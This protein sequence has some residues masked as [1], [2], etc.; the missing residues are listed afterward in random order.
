MKNQ[1]LLKVV[2]ILTVFFSLNFAF[3]QN[4]KLW[5]RFDNPSFLPT[6]DADGSLISSNEALTTLIGQNNMSGFEQ[7][8]PNSKNV[9]L[10]KVYEIACT[11]SAH[12]ITNELYKLPF[13]GLVEEAPNYQVLY[14]PDDYNVTL[15]ADYA[16]N[17]INAQGAWDISQGSD[18]VVIAIS[19]QNYYQHHEELQ[20]KIVYYD[21]TNLTT[22]THG[23]AIA[24]LAAGNTNNGIGFSS[25]GFKCKLALYK[26]SFNEILVAS[27][28]GVD[29]IN[30]SW[31]SGCFY[32][33][34][35]QDVINE[36]YNNG[37]F[38][39]A[40]AGNGTTC[41]GADNIVFP[42]S[43]ANVFAV[44]SVGPTDNHESIIGDPLSTHQHN[45]SV[46]ISAPGYGV[47]ISAA[48]SWYFN[49]SGTSYAAAYVSGTVGLMLAVNKCITNTDI[50]LILKSSSEN[51]DSLNPLYAGKIGSGRLD[52]QQALVLTTAHIGNLSLSTTLVDGCTSNDVAITASFIG[53]QAPHTVAWSNGA[54]SLDI[55]SLGAGANQITITDAHGCFVNQVVNVVD[56]QEPILSTQVTDVYCFGDNNGAV[57]LVFANPVE[58]TSVLWNN[59]NT[60]NALYNVSEGVYSANITYNG[61]LCSFTQTAIVQQPSVLSI[62]A[63]ITNIDSLNNTG[64]IDVSV[65]GGTAP[66]QFTWNNNE[67]TE[68]VYNLTA[69]TYLLTVTDAAG[70]SFT[71]FFEIFE[72]TTQQSAGVNTLPNFSI[73]AYPNPSTGNITISWTGELSSFELVNAAGQLIFKEDTFISNSMLIKNLGSGVYFAQYHSKNQALSKSLKFVVL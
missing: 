24:I 20:G 27:Y 38:I 73:N 70:C 23:T 12:L 6:L 14:T 56:V 35:A 32:S 9:E 21:S 33:Q 13:I 1:T 57:A 61:G 69:G 10:L 16:L 26:M 29:V 37:T 48:P 72:D 36:V 58:P 17:L 4:V 49:S 47:N 62:S 44:T 8:L 7:V 63:A 18:S 50:E 15:G 59:G 71:T 41:G 39:V 68:D 45:L 25:I 3:T 64:A 55:D 43:Y 52:A 60:G 22:A 46:D 30:L 19:D 28:N 42:A 40:S 5:V 65:V 51:I 66:Y 2:F 31:T 67:Q 34:I 53:G 54:N 11:G